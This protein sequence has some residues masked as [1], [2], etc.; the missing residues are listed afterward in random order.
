M[1]IAI[2][3]DDPAQLQLAVNVLN[4]V[5]HSCYTFTGGKELICSLRRDTY[6]LIVLDWN[7]GDMP[8]DKVLRWIRDNCYANLPVLFLTV[9]DAPEDI[10]SILNAGADDYLTK[11]VDR[12]ILLARV[13][14]LLRRSYLNHVTTAKLEYKDFLFDFQAEK[15]YRCGV[16]VA[17]SRKEFRV[18]ALLFRNMARPLSRTHMLQAIWKYSGGDVITRTVDTHVSVVRA[19]LQ[20]RPE[21]GYLVVPVYGYGYRLEDLREKSNSAA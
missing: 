4:A 11:P 5:G 13:S 18:A 16:H 19:R 6:D 7:L 15:V 17:L 9:R 14:A 8:G 21:N 20:L 2:L 1:R 12:D 10:V 3:E